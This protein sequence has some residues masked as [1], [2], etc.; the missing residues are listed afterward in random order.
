MKRTFVCRGRHQSLQRYPV[1]VDQ[2]LHF[3]TMLF[4]VRDRDFATHSKSLSGTLNAGLVS[5][6]STGQI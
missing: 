3:E 6:A 2:H 5:T 1:T 4:F